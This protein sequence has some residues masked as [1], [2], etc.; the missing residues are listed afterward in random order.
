MEGSMNV[1]IILADGSVITAES[2]TLEPHFVIQCPDRQAFLAVWDQLTPDNL[3]QLDVFNGDNRIAGFTD[4]ELI[5]TQTVNSYDGSLTAHFYLTGVPA[6]QTDPE[7]E[8]AY[9]IMTGEMQA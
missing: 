6:V 2:V 3:I 9:H 7:Y 5:G 8:T 1:K 4:C